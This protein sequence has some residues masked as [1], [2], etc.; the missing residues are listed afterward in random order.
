[1]THLNMSWSGVNRLLVPMSVMDSA[2]AAAGL[3]T[4]S[5]PSEDWVWA[6]FRSGAEELRHLTAELS[7]LSRILLVNFSIVMLVSKLK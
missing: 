6:G 1:M 3:N 2:W 7:S 4:S 5:S